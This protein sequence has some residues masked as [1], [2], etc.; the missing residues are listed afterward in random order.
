MTLTGAQVK[1]VLEQQWQ[2]NPASS[3]PFLKLGVNKEL[4]YTYDPTADVGQRITHVY[5]DGVEIDPAAEYRVVANSFLA[6]GGDNFTVL[7]EGTNRADTGKIDLQSMVD[8]FAANVV[9]TPDDVQRAVGVHLSAPDADGYDVGDALTIDLSSLDF[10]TNEIPAGSV[11]VS[12]GGIPLGTAAV[13]RTLLEKYDEIG[14]AQLVTTIPEGLYG[15][16]EL[17][18]TVPSTGTTATV[19]VVL[20]RA[21]SSISL[22]LT[23]PRPRACSTVIVRVSIDA[24]VP[25]AGTFEVFVDGRSIGVRDWTPNGAGEVKVKLP[26]RLGVGQHLLEVVYS[27]DGVVDPSS[28][29]TTFRLR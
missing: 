11:E 7:A 19:P 21:E 10:S 15:P 9:A 1:A 6:S 20:D 3:R 23:S 14:R 27:G 5:L 13:D 8:W 4:F 17:V 22:R 2:P 26:K 24:P 29:S 28:A 12:L 16:Q 25:I 18:V